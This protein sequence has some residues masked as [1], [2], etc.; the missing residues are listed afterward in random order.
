M[1]TGGNPVTVRH[2]EDFETRASLGLDDGPQGDGLVD[3][4]TVG[5]AEP[6]RARPRGSVVADGVVEAGKTTLSTS[7]N[8]QW[9]GVPPESIRK[10]R[11]STTQWDRQKDVKA[12]R[13]AVLESL[14]ESHGPAP[15][16]PLFAK[17][18]I[19]VHQKYC[20]QPL[21]YEGLA[22][23]MSPAVDAFVDYGVMADD[24]PVKYVVGYTMS[25]ERVAH[26]NERFVTV[27]VKE[28]T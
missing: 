28:A 25:H 12:M 17:V 24:E 5:L 19:H 18:R 7:Y 2:E 26:M 20:G 4:A 14:E 22:S 16:E 6:E 3:P 1:A 11:G 15:S 10:N 23:G 8:I 27:T 13:G 9:P 21:D